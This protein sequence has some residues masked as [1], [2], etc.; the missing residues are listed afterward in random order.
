[1]RAADWLPSLPVVGIV[2][3]MISGKNQR[4]GDFLVGSVVVHDNRLEEIRPD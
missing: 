3:M 2:T 4:L 1:M